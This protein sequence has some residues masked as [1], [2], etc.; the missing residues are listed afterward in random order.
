VVFRKEPLRFTLQQPVFPRL[1]VAV[2]YAPWP[3]LIYC[4][5]FIDVWES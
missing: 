5:S 2:E 4:S 3:G 1:R